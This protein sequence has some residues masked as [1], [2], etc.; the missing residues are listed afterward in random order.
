MTEIKLTESALLAKVQQL[1]TLQAQMVS[2][3]TQIQTIQFLESSGIGKE[4]FEQMV[5]NA[6]KVMS[7]S[8]LL[9]QKTKRYLIEVNT[10]FQATDGDLNRKML[11]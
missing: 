2:V 7:S 11:K 10:Q 8:E 3:T 4:Q 1:A 9:F 5:S 6:K